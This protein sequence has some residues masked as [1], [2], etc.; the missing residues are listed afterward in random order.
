[1]SE[2]GTCHS[3]EEKREERKK[4]RTRMKGLETLEGF[5][6]GSAVKNLP[7]IQET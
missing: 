5:P 3:G 7:A 1:M 6:G 4:Q 2:P